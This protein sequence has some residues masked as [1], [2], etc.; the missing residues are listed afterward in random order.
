MRSVSTAEFRFLSLFRHKRLFTRDMLMM[1]NIRVPGKLPPNPRSLA[2]F[3]HASNSGDRHEQSVAKPWSTRLSM[4]ALILG[5][6]R[7]FSFLSP[8]VIK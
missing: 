4:Q 5:A 2:I 1:K 7:T 8:L 6:N 3:L